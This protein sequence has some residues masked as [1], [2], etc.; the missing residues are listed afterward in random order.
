MSEGAV[1]ALHYQTRQPV[2]VRWREGR[3]TSIE[4]A[5]KP[6]AAAA[7]AAAPVESEGEANEEELL[8]PPKPRPAATAQDDEG[9]KE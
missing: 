6:A 2:E 3:I 1:T 7:K 8:K 9:E 4:V 5:A